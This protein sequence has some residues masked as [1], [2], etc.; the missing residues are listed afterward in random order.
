MLTHEFRLSLYDLLLSKL[1]LQYL[2][3]RHFLITKVHIEDVKFEISH[4]KANY[5]KREAL[6][7]KD[8]LV[9]AYDNVIEAIESLISAE[10]NL[11]TGDATYESAMQIVLSS[12]IK[13]RCNANSGHPS[14]VDFAYA[15]EWANY[16]AIDSPS[17]DHSGVKHPGVEHWY[18]NEP[19]FCEA[20][21]EW[22]PSEND[23]RGIKRTGRVFD[24]LPSYGNTLV[25][26]FIK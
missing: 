13:L 18:Q 15:P 9:S 14:S 2:T 4:L 24:G 10:R 5:L 12:L 17:V 25:S 8:Q 6:W 23:E 20:T 22:N 1:E 7:D 16:C 11:P 21:G 19:T 3:Q 26:R